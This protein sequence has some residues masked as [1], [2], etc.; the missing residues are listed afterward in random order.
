[1]LFGVKSVK[2]TL[3]L[4]RGARRQRFGDSWH[5]WSVRG[6]SGAAAES[7]A[8]GFATILARI[9]GDDFKIASNLGT[10][11]CIAPFFVLSFYLFRSLR[12]KNSSLGSVQAIRI[13]V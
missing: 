9:Y 2:L 10:F 12:D 3:A 7:K 6:G 5:R 13:K 4:P 11:L 8:T 1:M